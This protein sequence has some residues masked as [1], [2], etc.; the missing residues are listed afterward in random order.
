VRGVAGGV[1]VRACVARVSV[2]L[3]V[4]AR[5][6]GGGL[7]VCVFA[8]TRRSLRKHVRVNACM[9]ASASSACFQCARRDARFFLRACVCVCERESHALTALTPIVMTERIPLQRA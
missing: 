6:G 5:L 8:L 9:R 2:V 3:C 4:R 1:S 7:C